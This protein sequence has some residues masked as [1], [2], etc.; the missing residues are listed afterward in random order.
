MPWVTPTQGQQA[1]AVNPFDFLQAR[2]PD[3]LKRTGAD[4]V[5]LT[6]HDSLKIT[7]SNG[8]WHW[9]SRGFGGR[10]PVKL[11]MSVWDM[12]YPNAVLEVLEQRH[13]LPKRPAQQREPLRKPFA[14]PPK[15]RDNDKA[16]AYLLG[17]GIDREI[18]DA[19]IAAGTVY[20]SDGKYHNCVF[21]GKDTSGKPRFACT[22]GIGTDFKRDVAG[23]EKKYNFTLPSPQQACCHVQVA[24]AAID[25]LSLATLGKLSGPNPWRWQHMHY[26]SLGGTSPLALMQF[27]KDHPAVDKVTLGL[28][29]DPAGRS[30]AE[31]IV[32]AVHA[33]PAL[34][35]RQIE[36]SYVPPP[37]GKDYN[38]YLQE[39]RTEAQT[40]PQ[41]QASV[42]AQRLNRGSPLGQQEQ[43]ICR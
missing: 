39:K 29:A 5:C 28:D 27:L 20:E 21:V 31:K 35:A 40:R 7:P 9:A 18:V 25:V 43:A 14:L 30:G 34:A 6:E 38:V 13:N 32:A 4:E 23:S 12:T 41:K 24:E 2:Y 8:K 37:R 17:R 26:L 15:N 16:I 3:H 36:I 11:L 22:R 10:D 33:D 19:C 1:K 42:Q